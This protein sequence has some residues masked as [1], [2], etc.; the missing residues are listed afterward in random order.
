MGLEC[1]KKDTIFTNVAMTKDGDVWW[2]GLT[3]ETPEGLT[4]W[5]GDD[6]DA[7]R[8]E[9]G[10]RPDQANSRFCS[11]LV[12]CPSLD[13]E[14]ANRPDGVPIDAI[15]FGSLGDILFFFGGGGCE[16]ASL[17]LCAFA[18]NVAP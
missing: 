10:A 6:F 11:P 18:V 4:D 5:Y 13:H 15:I 14:G 1:T 3:K 7:K 12:N 16:I 2:D 17:L 9:K 8:H